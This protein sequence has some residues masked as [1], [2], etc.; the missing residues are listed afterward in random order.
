MKLA[1]LI[2]PFEGAAS[3]G[4]RNAFLNNLYQVIFLLI[5]VEL[6]LNSFYHSSF[7]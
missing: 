5:Y 2:Q 3:W 4:F 6:P 1:G 7:L